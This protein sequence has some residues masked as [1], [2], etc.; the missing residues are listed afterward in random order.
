MSWRAYTVHGIALKHV[1]LPIQ[2]G[3][4]RRGAG[5]RRWLG[6]HR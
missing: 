1:F 5:R 6:A 2:F 4:T 3:A